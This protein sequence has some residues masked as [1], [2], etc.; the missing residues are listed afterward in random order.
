[1]TLRTTYGLE[2]TE[3]TQYV[4]G[5]LPLQFDQVDAT[6]WD[7]TRLREEVAAAQERPFDIA[8]SVFRGALFTRAADDHVLLLTVHHIAADGWSGWLLLEELRALYAAQVSGG[9]AG[10]PMPR[11]AYTDHVR[12]QRELLEG[13]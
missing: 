4:H 8:A 3:A 5:S 1:A 7:E 6:A 12:W 2:G 11:V 9:A 10:L 13:A